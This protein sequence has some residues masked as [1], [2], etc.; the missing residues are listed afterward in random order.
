M[1]RIDLKGVDDHKQRSEIMSVILQK[2]VPSLRAKADVRK[3]KVSYAFL[4]RR[5][6]DAQDRLVTSTMT[7]RRI[8]STD[9]TLLEKDD[10]DGRSPRAL[11]KSNITPAVPAL[12]IPP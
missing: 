11:E 6:T 9:K 2:N 12:V 8:I 4:S 5:D 10:G 7:S 1:I 3:R